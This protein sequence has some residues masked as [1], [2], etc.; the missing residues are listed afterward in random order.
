M[1]A[2]SQVMIRIGAQA[3]D[4]ISEFRRLD[5]AVGDSMTKT[6]RA[7]QAVKRAAV[8]ATI[9]LAALAAGAIDATK[10]AAEDAA[11]Q[12]KLAGTLRRVA[13]ASDAAVKG[14]E[15]FISALSQQVGVADD[16]LRPAL[17]KIAT[18][19]KDVTK[20][21]DGLK[22][23]LDVA[24]Q[25]GKPLETVSA[26]LAKAYSGQGTALA[27]L[28]PGIDKAAIKSGEFADVNKELA[29]L[30]GGAA[31]EAANT[32]EGKFRRFSITIQETKESIGQALLPALDVLLGILQ[33]VAGWVQNHTT[34]FKALA[35]AVG[36][37][38]IA[39]VTINAAM[40]VASA[41]STVWGVATKAAA[42]AQWLLNAALSANPIGVV[43]V[44]VAALVAGVVLLWR[45]SDTFRSVVSKVWD[46]LR[47]VGAVI[48]DTVKP[49]F[50][51]IA[52]VVETVV[53]LFRGDFSG[54]WEAA[55]G[56]VSSVA[57]YIG[58]ALGG[59]PAKILSFAAS[60]GGAALSLGKTILSKLGEGVG[61]LAQ[62]IA[63]EI[64]EIAG[65]A[66][67]LPGR[68]V[69]VVKSIG[70]RVLY[71]FGQGV[72][73]LAGAV[74]DGIKAIGSM[75]AALPGTV[76]DWLQGIGGK[77]LGWFSNG[78]GSI[79]GAVW[80]KITDIAKAAS[81]LPGDVID[82]LKGIGA[83]FVSWIVNGIADL[84]FALWNGAK[85]ALSW[86][87]AK[88]KKWLADHWPDIPGLPGPPASWGKPVG[89]PGD[90]V[91]RES[92]YVST[93]S[94]Q[95][96]VVTPASQTIITEEMVARAVQRVLVQSDARNGVSLLYA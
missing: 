44:A 34:L 62:W 93:F 52:G 81:A 50:D 32:A 46:V 61:N 59:I 26:A 21:Q 13:G 5:K 63:G 86:V 36:G 66:L 35:V 87:L 76:I 33:T 57:E 31:A 73:S 9:A 18:A 72:G 79:A 69:E 53:D 40:K 11:A 39:V 25:T 12:E 77:V 55:K 42:A 92:A 78:V 89:N 54:A 88:I 22:I 68:V 56:V 96:V 28:L 71:W 1:G 95:R 38:A 24:A 8:P 90:Y 37:L 20:A 7:Q 27:K 51:A 65:A 48:W 75:A 49:A 4:A 64:L 82:W 16:E 30:T 85:S 19:T 14:A 58:N 70:G 83:N 67:E 6:E 23:A 41:V 74:W 84:P 47:D 80:D 29:R 17:S 3:S 43:L 60:I 2:A 15:D 94:V 45:E 10:A 91:G